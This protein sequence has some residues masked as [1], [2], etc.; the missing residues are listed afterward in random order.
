MVEAS[1]PLADLKLSAFLA[2]RQIV[3]WLQRVFR[4]PSANGYLM[5][6]FA[7]TQSQVLEQ[8]LHVVGQIP[9]GLKGAYCRTGPNPLLS[10]AGGYHW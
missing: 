4:T 7:P 8:D 9:E 3:Y 1:G 6:N 5:G 2:A 10:P